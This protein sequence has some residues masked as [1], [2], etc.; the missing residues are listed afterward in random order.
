MA[1]ALLTANTAAGKKMQKTP[2]QQLIG[3]LQ[4]LQKKGVMFGHQDALFY[5]TTW[6]WEYGRSDV[7]DVCG[8]YPAVLGC[9]LG[10][11]ELGRDRNLDSVPFAEMR[12]Q[13]IGHWRRGGIV[14]VSWHAYNPVT[15]ED[16]W[17]TEGDA[18]A[19]VLPGGKE[20]GKMQHWLGRIAGF[21]ASLKDDRGNAIPVIFRP[22]HEMSGGWFWWGSRQCTP[23]QYIALYRLTHEAMRR[24]GLRN[25]V[26]SYSPN[27]E[28]S[29]TPEHFFRFYPGDGCVDLLGVDLYQNNGRQDFIDQCQNELHIMATY[30]GAHRKLYALTEAG[31]RN[32]PDAAWYSSTLLPGLQGF[33]PCYVLLWRN[34]W[35]KPEENFGP[36]P[37]KS[38]AADF[39][40]IYRERAFLFRSQTGPAQAATTKKHNRKR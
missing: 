10:G 34:A 14:T 9:E 4:D 39:R 13:I 36:A 17:H 12:R 24:R 16:A 35:D 37:E 32:T 26:W 21:L 28:A 8:D 2:A 27:A 29:D 38:C 18:V 6:K 22:W 33:K 15:E 19:Q 23:E 11:L 1:A 20:A 40:K 7:N 5:G 30:A 25:I 31:Y 3:R